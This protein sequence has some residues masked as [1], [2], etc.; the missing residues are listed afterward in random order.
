[1]L[2]P[3]AR[4]APRCS[5]GATRRPGCAASTTAGSSTPRAPASTCRRSRPNRTSRTRCASA[6][7]R[8]TSR[9][10]IVW[11]YM[12]PKETMP[13]FRDLGSESLPPEQW[14]ASKSLRDCNWV[15][16]LEGNLDT[17]HISLPA[18]CH[19]LERLA[20]RRTDPPATRR[21]TDDAGYCGRTTR[22]PTSR[23]K[24]PGTASATPACARRPTAHATRASRDFIHALP[25]LRRSLAGGRRQLH[26]DGADRRQRTG[27]SRRAVGERDEPR[28]SAPTARLAAHRGAYRST[29]RLAGRGA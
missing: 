9:G 10:G 28:Q 3:P 24:T 29:G 11:T 22:R 7:T 1:M 4:E 18:P 12:G 13:P 20:G 15:Q 23:S 14:R 6:P 16:G 25:D 8:R 21:T 27:A 19:A 26:H 5:S 2:T 17:S